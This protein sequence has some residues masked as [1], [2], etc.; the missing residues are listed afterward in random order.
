MTCDECSKELHGFCEGG[1]CQCDK[2]YP[3]VRLPQGIE[4]IGD[5]LIV[6]DSMFH[7]VRVVEEHLNGDDC[8]SLKRVTYRFKP[9]KK[10]ITFVSSV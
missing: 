6:D 9:V 2:C 8:G 3:R 4:L 7:V 5:T 10:G 1:D